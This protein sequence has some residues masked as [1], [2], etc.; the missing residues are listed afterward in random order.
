M[1]DK[2]P[3]TARPRVLVSRALPTEPAVRGSAS[4]FLAEAGRQGVEADRRML[5][6]G[7]EPAGEEVASCLRVAPGTDVV[8]RRKMMTA[9]GVPV[10]IATSYFRADLFGG[11][12]LAEPG[13]VRPSLQSALIALGYVFGHAEENLVARPPTGFERETL[14]LDPGEWV[15]RVL[16]AGYSA[17]DT[18]VH[19]LETVCAGSRHVFPIRQVSG[20][21]EF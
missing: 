18:P 3:S 20:Y 13:F 8:A 12:R 5:Y 10:R 2:T 19:V 7:L 16:R 9:D 1:D 4:L 15:V 17:D 6:V 14:E 21:D 11:T